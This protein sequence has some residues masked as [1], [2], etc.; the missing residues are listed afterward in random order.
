[1]IFSTNSL[2]VLNVTVP[3]L[4]TDAIGN[5]NFRKIRDYG[6]RCHIHDIQCSTV[7]WFLEFISCAH[8]AVMLAKD[9]PQISRVTH[10]VKPLPS[11]RTT[12]QVFGR[13]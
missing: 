11:I 10:F 7:V 13:R 4:V 5:D 9:V 12:T 3:I 6:C 2:K 1:M 8:S